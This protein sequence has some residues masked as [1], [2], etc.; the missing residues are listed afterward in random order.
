ML[1][2]SRGAPGNDPPV[3]F[4]LG[5]GFLVWIFAEKK[6]VLLHIIWYNDNWRFSTEIGYVFC[7][8]GGGVLYLY[9][10]QRHMNRNTR[11]TTDRVRRI[12]NADTRAIKT[13]GIY[14]E[15]VY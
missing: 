8:A 1:S 9:F 4:S 15:E 3:P 10:G 5:Y 2:G 11:N 12:R 14:G 7:P 13:G 6:R